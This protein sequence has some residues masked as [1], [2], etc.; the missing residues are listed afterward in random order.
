MNYLS[1]NFQS[2]STTA[3]NFIWIPVPHHIWSTHS[4]IDEGFIHG[5][6]T[7]ENMKKL[8][9]TETQVTIGDSG[10]LTRTKHGDWNRCQIHDRKLHSMTLSD[11]DIIPD[12]HT[13]LFIMTWALKRGFQV[14]SE[15]E[16]IILQK[17]QPKFAFTIK[18]GTTAA[19]G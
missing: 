3:I 1:W 12:L 10:T 9:N 15:N 7:W 14:T 11:T 2:K 13:D 17:I 6:N 18:W 4:I 16:A 5:V 19:S 8:H